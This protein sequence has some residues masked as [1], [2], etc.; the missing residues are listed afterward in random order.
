MKLETKILIF[1]GLGILLLTSLGSSEQTIQSNPNQYCKE[2]TQAVPVGFIHNQETNQAQW[3]YTCQT[4]GA[5][6]PK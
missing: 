6:I 3:I 5:I 2:N 4:T 1:L